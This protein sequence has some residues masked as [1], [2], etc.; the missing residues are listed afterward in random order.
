[1]STTTSDRLHVNRRRFLGAAGGAALLGTVPVGP[2]TAASDPFDGWFD[3]VPNYDG[4]TDRRGA[5]S[6]RV[7]VGPD[8][9][10]VFDPPVIRVDTGTTVVWEWADGFHDVSAVDGG[11]Q[12]E[13]TGDV[14]HEF[15]HT[16][17]AEGVYTYVCSPHE[18]MEMKGAVVVGDDAA[19]GAAAV[20]AGGS[21]DGELQ[22]D[23]YGAA[24][25]G[26]TVWAGIVGYI[27]W[28]F[29]RRKR[30]TPAHPPW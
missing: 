20:T 21:G 25:L 17:D 14:G 26:G 2:A 7:L 1:M 12:S 5:E 9:D 24:F 19:S 8:G 29:G 4:V 6:V 28:G 13:M 11:F 30:P 23:R 10:L 15:T 3:A 16:F 18:A 27:A 22:W